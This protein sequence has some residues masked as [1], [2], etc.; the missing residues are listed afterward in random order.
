MDENV[1]MVLKGKLVEMMVHI[2]AQIHRKYIM[3]DRKRSD[4]L[5]EAAKS[6][7]WTDESQSALLQKAAQGARRIWVCYKLV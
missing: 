1:L 2:A 3:V 7:V 5:C 4:V 6:T